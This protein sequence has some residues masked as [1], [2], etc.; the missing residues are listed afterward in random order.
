M[1]DRVTEQDQAEEQRL[2]ESNAEARRIRE[3]AIAYA[4]RVLNGEEPWRENPD[5]QADQEGLPVEGVPE[6]EPEQRV[7]ETAGDV[8]SED[9]GA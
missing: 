4:D 5:W 2:E 9:D 6:R 7:E 1:A 3:E 8:D